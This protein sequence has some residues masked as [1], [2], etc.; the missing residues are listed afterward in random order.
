MQDALLAFLAGG[1]DPSAV[2]NLDA[3]FS[4]RLAAMLG[5]A[6]GGGATIYSGYRSV[7][8]QQRLWEEALAKYGDPEIADNWVA[9]PGTSNHNHGL[10]VDLRYASPE[11]QDWVHQNAA[12]YGLT[13]P[14]SHEP[15]H[16]EMIDGQPVAVPD[17]QTQ[18]AGGAA[19]GGLAA[20]AA[21]SLADMFVQAAPAAPAQRT[22]TTSAPMVP[23]ENVKPQTNPTISSLLAELQSASMAPA[24][25][26]KR[27]G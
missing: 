4:R 3:E 26:L 21:P 10:A 11:V 14:M 2:A 5:Q 15:W 8:H 27:M 12:N 16:I 6:P 20:P 19:P 25:N 22:P 24:M 23:T 1:K 13:F 9:R 7:D 18:M 17:G